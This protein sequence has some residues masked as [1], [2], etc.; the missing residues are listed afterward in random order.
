ML[1]KK[2][3]ALCREFPVAG[4]V[5]AAKLRFAPWWVNHSHNLNNKKGKIMEMTK[6]KRSQG[7]GT[8]S[9]SKS[10]FNSIVFGKEIIMKKIKMK[11]RFGL[12]RQKSRSIVENV[13]SGTKAGFKSFLNLVF[14]QKK[15]RKKMENQK[16]KSTFSAILLS[17]TLM[18]TAF[19]VSP[20]AA[21]KYVT[22]PTTGKVVTAPEYGGSITW[23]AD[24]TPEHTD[25]YYHH[26]PGTYVSAVVEKLGIADWA[27]PRDVFNFRTTYIPPALLTGNLA[28]SWEQPDAK[29][30]IFH[31]RKGVHWHK[32][33]PMN[34]RE[35]TA[36]DIVYNYH[37]V[38]GTGSGYTEAT[39][40]VSGPLVSLPFDSIEA[41]DKY[42][43][44]VKL[45]EPRLDA[46]K[47]ILVQNIMYIYPPEV[48]KE[49][50][51]VKD[52]RDLVGTGPFM[53]T[54]FVD[55]TSVTWTKN[56]NYWDYDEKYPENRLPY[57]DE[58]AMLVI[59]DPATRMSA[60]RT[61]KLD[62]MAMFGGYS[63]LRG[64]GALDNV[65]SLKRSNPELVFETMSYR[66]ESSWSLNSQ[67]PPFD[68]VNVRHAMQMALDLDEINESFWLGYADTTPQGFLGVGM[69]GYVT[70]FADWPEE[71]KGYYTYNPAGAEALLDA[72]GLTR[73]ADGIRFKAILEVATVWDT[74]YHELAAFYWEAIG[75]DVEF[76]AD[77]R[78]SMWS[79]LRST[80]S[81]LGIW[82]TI[83]GYEDKP[84]GE[85]Q[86]FTT[87]HMFNTAN[88]NDP[89]YNA[90]VDA[91]VTATTVEEQMRLVTEIDRYLTEKHWHI[92][93]ARVP[94]MHVLQ[95]WVIG[96]NGETDLG[97][98]D[99]NTITARLWIDSAL[100]K[101]MGY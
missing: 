81:H 55:G 12:N 69:I 70:P 24:N 84:I 66:S 38:T 20:A 39:P 76:F 53:M 2:L 79:R 100:K 43:M 17:L 1:A 67:L 42:T 56:P 26:V 37:R 18:V 48:I 16:S 28:E 4:A 30:L 89:T 8:K 31:I 62:A 52:W 13:L 101:E 94:Q 11:K 19:W 65:E 91:A 23:P 78:A 98:M 14:N 5:P 27:T 29:T 47:T 83:S 64:A 45:T 90:M 85:I 93:G 86:T 77:E 60:M 49:K 50:G 15:E 96:F 54:D 58:V 75:I 87:G 71:L 44:V 35:L 72:A 82:P 57:V 95:P 99:R 61:G 88:A 7:R 34:G 59:P 21:Q 74:S 33:P 97:D 10:L 36:D 92:W 6:N 73:G 9:L 3:F 25:T 80:G 68:D 63:Q 46:L 41:T 40:Y 51:N 22:D 32:K